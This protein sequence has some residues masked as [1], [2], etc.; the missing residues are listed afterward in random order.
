MKTTN[1]Q[2]IK[3]LLNLFFRR[4][5][6]GMMLKLKTPPSASWEFHKYQFSQLN[7][8]QKF[9]NTNILEDNLLFYM[10]SEVLF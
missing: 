7:F 9:L 2:T 6:S 5:I 8:Y 1:K 10:K 3:H 4:S